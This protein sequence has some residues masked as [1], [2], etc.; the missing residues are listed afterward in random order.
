MS[1]VFAAERVEKQH[2]DF[3][4]I[5]SLMLL[6]GVG[7]V[8]LFSSSYFRSAV[9]LGN[10][11]RLFTD[12]CI[13]AAIG[14]VLAVVASKIPLDRLRAALPWLLGISLALMLLTFIP[15]VGVEY[16]GGRRWFIIF[17]RSFQPSELVKLCLILYLASVLDK[18][19]GK[20]DLPREGLVPPFVMVMIFAGLIFMQNNFSTAMFI[21]LVSLSIFF[22]AG[23]QLRYFGLTAILLAPL[24][25]STAWAAS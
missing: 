8:M 25:V 20:L 11:L 3:L 12:Q 17:G 9:I 19:Q 18:K 15:G 23:V 2:S 4:M 14:V 22:A 13:Y 24:A 5:C 16:L 10:P 1:Q 6:L 7:L 21:L